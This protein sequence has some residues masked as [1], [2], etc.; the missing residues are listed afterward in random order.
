MGFPWLPAILGGSSILSGITSYLNYSQQADLMDWQKQAQYTTWNREDNAVQRR[1]ADLKAAGLSP[2]LAAGS[3]ATTS[4]PVRPNAPQIDLDPM[5]KAAMAMQML[6]QKADIHRTNAEADYINM[7]KKLSEANIKNVNAQSANHALENVISRYNYGKAKD[8]GVRTDIRG[9]SAE[10]QQLL[11]AFGVTEKTPEAKKMLKSGFS[12]LF[13][14]F[15]AP[16]Q[17]VRTKKDI[18]KELRDEAD[19][20]PSGKYKES[21]EEAIRQFES[22]DFPVAPR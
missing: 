14:K 20:M 1:V 16:K 12:D 10:I 15:V 11:N 22:G 6:G 13:E 3:A 18:L 9:F 7:Q 21:F 8:L 4:A 19:K 2:T 5:S 17:E